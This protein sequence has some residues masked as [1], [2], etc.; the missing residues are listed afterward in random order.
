MGRRVIADDVVKGILAGYDPEK[1]VIAAYCSHSSLQIFHGAKREGFRTL[2]IHERRKDVRYYDAFPAAK[3]D[4]FFPMD[5]ITDIL[6]R[7]DELIEKNVILIPH[8]SLVEYLKVPNFEKLR[9]PTFGNKAVLAWES[10]RSAQREWLVGGGLLMPME[11]K[12]PRDI[13]RPVLCKQGGAKGGRGFFIAKSHSDWV[14]AISEGDLKAEDYTTIQEYI[15]GT[16]YYLHFFYTPLRDDGFRVGEGR[17]ELMSMDR[18]DE[19]NIDEMYKLGS[20]TELKDMDIYPSFVVTGNIPLVIRESLLPKVFQMGEGV[21][22]KSI[23][24]FG[25]MVGSFC[26]ET[27]ITDKLDFFTFEI[28]ARIVAGTNPYPTGSPYAAYM[29][30]NIS[31]GQRIAREIKEAIRMGALE[32]ILS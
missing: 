2:G 18:R 7:Q 8:G 1:V 31:T 23:E 9:L 13:D 14:K 30:D 6:D 5:S 16:R 12:D 10:D 11:V 19:T 17:L 26:L 15:L 21:V 22:N 4:E 28:S 3:P 32:S 27:V 29:E 24:L 25:G 20:Q